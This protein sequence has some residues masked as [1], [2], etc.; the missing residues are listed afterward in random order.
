MN[1]EHLEEQRTLFDLKRKV[2]KFHFEGLPD[3]EVL[4]VVLERGRLL[5]LVLWLQETKNAKQ[6]QNQ[7]RI[8]L[9]SQ[10]NKVEDREPSYL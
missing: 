3:E 8:E 10:V 1:E 4:L 5:E 2:F 6:F 7:N 9:I